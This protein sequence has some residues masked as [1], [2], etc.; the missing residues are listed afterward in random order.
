M[1]NLHDRARSSADLK[2]GGNS[3]ALA[4]SDY[5]VTAVAEDND[6]A[7]A[8]QRRYP[9]RSGANRQCTAASRSVRYGRGRLCGLV[10]YCVEGSGEY[11]G[12]YT[13][14]NRKTLAGYFT[15]GRCP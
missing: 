15:L 6:G 10:S 8:S 9:A 2:S 5:S 13:I 4:E 12:L 11:L 1:T 7:R 14:W 3:G